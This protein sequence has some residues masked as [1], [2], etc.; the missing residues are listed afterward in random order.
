[1]KI[2]SKLIIL[3]VVITTVGCTTAEERVPSLAESFANYFTI[4]VAVDRSAV[5]SINDTT[6]I[7]RQF[8]SITMEED[9]Y[10]INMQPRPNRWRWRIADEL[11]NFAHRNQIQVRGN[12]LVRHDQMPEWFYFDGERVTTKDSLFARIDNY[13]NTIMTRYKGKISCWDVVSN[14]IADD[15]TII[16]KQ[17]TWLYQI[18]G[19]EYIEHA[20]RCAHKADSTALLFYNDYNVVRPEKLT[21]TYQM[22]KNLINKGVHIDGVGIQGHWSLYEPSEQHLQTAI[23]LFRSLGLQVHITQ[24]DVSLYKWE[25]NQRRHLRRNE[26]IRFDEKMKFQQAKQYSTIFKVLRNNADVVT[27]VTFWGIDDRHSWL[28]NYPVKGRK[29]HP[30]L[31]DAYRCT[32]PAFNFIMRDLQQSDSIKAAQKLLPF[33]L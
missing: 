29:N 26:T 20:F 6:F 25:K 2:V 19:E 33:K 11:V 27:N 13:I 8:N 15:T 16:V 1:M 14:A 18:C 4:G 28:N 22:L 12:C 17:N 24:L 7:L 9:M 21:R 23:D 30:L 10:P 5:R 3:S 32:K 31:F